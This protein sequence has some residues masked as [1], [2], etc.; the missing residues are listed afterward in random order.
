MQILHRDI[1]PDN[2]IVQENGDAVLLD[3]GSARQIIGDMTQGL[4]VILKPGYAPVEQYA[5]DATL[6]QGPFTDLY[7]LSAVLYFAITK[8]PPPTSIG[9]MIS[10]PIVALTN[11][12]P[13]GYGAPLLAA[14]DKGLAVLAQDRPQTIDEFRSLL[15]I[16]PL[17]PLPARAP[18]APPRALPPVRP[19]EP[20]ATASTAPASPDRRRLL[21]GAGAASLLAIAAAGLYALV[22]SSNEDRS[23][24]AQAQARPP[25]AAALAR[26]PTAP[27]A[28][29]P[30]PA[31]NVVS[32]ASA[33]V[34]PAAPV[35]TS[36]ANRPSAPVGV[37]YRLRIR[38]WGTLFV[39]DKSLGVSPPLKHVV[40]THGKHTIR[41]V[42]PGFPEYLATIEVGKNK[43]GVIEHDFSAARH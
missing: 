33:V 7:A 34:A 43:P 17:E 30:A 1:S 40:L 21:I 2:I 23:M 9:R 41:I 36:S 25:V 12:A 31:A 8:A 37:S 16:V 39:D 24:P 29:S 18:L 26:A 15:G 3:F 22:P 27:P 10:D 42:N 14:I 32:G 35:S 20:P 13:A 11:Q 28:A 19:V 38:P 5:G 4:T 6:Q